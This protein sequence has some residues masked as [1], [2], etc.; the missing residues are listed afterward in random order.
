MTW[1][2]TLR[3]QLLAW[4]TLCAAIL[5][6]VFAGLIW[7]E[8]KSFVSLR[9]TG[10]DLVESLVREGFEQRGATLAGPNAG[11]LA[12]GETGIGRM[13]EP[14]EILVAIEARLGAPR[15]PAVG[16]VACARRPRRAKNRRFAGWRR[17]ER[18]AGRRTRRTPVKRGA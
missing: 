14:A 18:F 4:M 11:P 3:A 17:Q 2:W 15:R 6:V 8:Q 1:R 10:D 12:E 16:A 9:D 5:A 7:R 13:A